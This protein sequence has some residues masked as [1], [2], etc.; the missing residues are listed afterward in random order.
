MPDAYGAST[1][2]GCHTAGSDESDESDKSD[3]SDALPKL[4]CSLCIPASVRG[5]STAE[6][7][8]SRQA[9]QQRTPIGVPPRL[10]HYLV[11]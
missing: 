7:A 1:R 11:R 8:I 4:T 9:V 3:E 5:G 6:D 2:K 10:T